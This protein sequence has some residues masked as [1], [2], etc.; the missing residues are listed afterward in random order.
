MSAF[1]ESLVLT[2]A[3]SGVFNAQTD[4]RYWMM[5]GPFGGWVSA[6]MLKAAMAAVETPEHPLSIT[7]N[8][9]QPITERDVKLVVTPQQLTRTLSFLKVDAIQLVDGKDQLA[10]SA[11]VILG[12]R[13]GNVQFK[14]LAPPE[15]LPQPETLE[16]VSARVGAPPFFTNY[17][18]RPIIG[19]PFQEAD[20]SYTLAYARDYPPS[21]LDVISLTALAD[22]PSPRL[23]HRRAGFVPIAT[24]TLS[25]YFHGLPQEIDAQGDRPV[26][27]AA[28]ARLIQAGFFDQTLE[29]WSSSGALLATS[30]QMV[31]FKDA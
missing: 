11:M 9:F 8:F 12:R 25:V 16:P 6:I 24:V 23:F 10:A 2:P 13:R 20:D 28:R 22:I 29:I 21:P 27:M 14:E 18:L 30:E 26:I 1:N 31:W 15:H 5:K 19:R 3:E 4:P 7:I 17:E